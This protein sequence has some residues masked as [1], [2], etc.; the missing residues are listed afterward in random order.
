MVEV[1][2][3]GV[4]MEGPRPDTRE[5]SWK[6]LMFEAATRAYR[7]AHVDPRTDVDT[8]VTAAEDYWEGFSIF[9]EFVPDQ[10]GAVM[11]P[12]CT[13]AGEGLQALA[14][15][16]LQLK[17]GRF[18]VA[19]VE[20]HSKASELE[21]FDGIL[22]HSL[23]PIFARPLGYHPY[24]LAGLD[25][26][27]LAKRLGLRG[28]DFARI[29]LE[30]YR[31]VHGSSSPSLNQILNSAP[32]FEPLRSGETAPLAD[33]C[34]VLV[35]A[36][37]GRA[38]QLSE[39]PVWI[40]GLG[41]SSD[42]PWVES[43]QPGTAPFVSRAAREAY[44]AAGIEPTRDVDIVEVDDRFAHSEVMHAEALEY[45][46]PRAL[47]S[48]VRSGEL[49]PGGTPAVNPSGGALGNGNLLEANGLFRMA[50]AVYQLRGRAG[51][52]QV[53]GARVA[54]VQSWRGPPTATGA[55]AVLGVE[56]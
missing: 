49:G 45:T 24:L 43:R 47:A 7:E 33:G 10:L 53:E 20:A 50:H 16:Y 23:D 4:G 3:V 5:L 56:A 48:A 6:E 39:Q 34:V 21:T 35:L 25:K 9:D 22:R 13:V 27:A 51:G 18:Q 44:A 19:V 32:L 28:K 55:V 41:W 31:R 1:A 8:F 37:D 26:A 54:V 36:A 52:R 12:T 14:A 2:V 38:R 30:N 11:R 40:K 29:A 46:S 17:T 15:A 42:S